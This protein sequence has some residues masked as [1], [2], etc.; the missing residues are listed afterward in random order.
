MNLK[1]Y[2]WWAWC[3]AYLSS[4]ETDEGTQEGRGPQYTYNTMCFTCSY[5]SYNHSLGMCFLTNIYFHFTYQWESVP[6]WQ[7]HTAPPPW[8]NGEQIQ[9]WSVAWCRKL[10]WPRGHC[11][12]SS[13]LWCGIAPVLPC[14]TPASKITHKINSV[15]TV[16]TKCGLSVSKYF[17]SYSDT[18]F[19][20]YQ[21]FF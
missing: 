7:L 17:L 20:C 9:M 8:S 15:H 14:P 1:H 16:V 11:G 4:Y 5:T 2:A 12:S 10:P 13:G 3:W 6:H 21:S 19:W 18:L